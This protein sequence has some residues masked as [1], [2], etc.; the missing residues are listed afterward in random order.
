MAYA[1]FVTAMMAFFL[2][3]WIIAQNNSVRRA[4]ARY[5][6]DPRGMTEKPGTGSPLLP[7]TKTGEP[8]GPS[9]MP[10]AQPGA[11]GGSESIFRKRTADV[12][13]DSKKPD[14]NLKELVADKSRLYVIHNGDRNYA[15][16]IVLF[17]PGS[18]RLDAEAK[19]QLLRLLV[20]LRGKPNK[21][22]VRGHAPPRPS[23]PGAGAKNP[24]KLSYERC[25]SVQKFLEAHGIEPER[26]R[27][28]QGGP[29]E[30]YSLQTGSAKQ[31]YNSRVE[32]YMLDEYAEDLMGTPEERAKR[33]V[34]SQR[35]QE[36]GA[37]P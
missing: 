20:D 29:Y 36:A 32:V 35:Q 17:P 6:N 21:L 8:P 16:T 11:P 1:D 12:P 19:N 23:S 18:S 22:E 34:R 24:W 33:F 30:P 37:K 13:Y 5:F 26:I 25:L 14:K 28:S 9:I 10:S 31:A 2:V 4:I 7:I 15:G 3:M 27:L